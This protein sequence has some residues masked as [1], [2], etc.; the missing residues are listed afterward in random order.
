MAPL[1]SD[2]TADRSATIGSGVGEPQTRAD[3][4]DEGGVEEGKV[5]EES[6]VKAAVSDFGTLRTGETGAFRDPCAA[7][8]RK[9]DRTV[10]FRGG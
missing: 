3:F 6:V 2:A 10:A 8:H 4:G 1:W 9:P 7:E 5:S